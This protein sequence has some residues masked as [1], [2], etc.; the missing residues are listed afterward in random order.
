MQAAPQQRAGYCQNQQA[1]GKGVGEQYP[2]VGH[3]ASLVEISEG[4]PGIGLFL[5]DMRL[6]ISLPVLGI[7]A[8]VGRDEHDA[9]VFR[10]LYSTSSPRGR[11]A[12]LLLDAGFC[13]RQF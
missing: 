7:Y 9:P 11:A 3:P 8:E 10:L 6:R 4:R 2:Y 13:M 12:R 1:A 5:L